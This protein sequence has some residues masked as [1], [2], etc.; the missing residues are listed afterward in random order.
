[1]MDINL[2]REEPQKVKDNMIRKGYSDVSIVDSVSSMDESWRSMKKEVDNLRYERNKVSKEINT[3]KK[4]GKD[5]SEALNRAK[6]IPSEIKAIED[7][8]DELFSQIKA[9][10]KEIPNILHESVPQGNSDAD[11]IELKRFG[12]EPI[13]KEVKPHQVLAEELGVADFDSAA[14]TSGA[15]FY[16]LEGELALLNQALIRLAIET[17]YKKGFQYVETPLLIRKDIIDYVA[18]LADQESMIYKIEGEDLFLIGTSEHS[19]IGRFV[20]QLIPAQ[21]LPIK[22]TSYSM[23]FRREKG[24]HG[25]DEK[26]LFRTHQ[27]NKVEM[28]VICQP[29]ESMKFFDEMWNITVEIFTSLGLPTRTLQICT[30]DL[31]VLKH[32][33]YDVEVYSPR[34]DEWIEV[35]SCSNLTTHQARGLG[36]RADKGGEKF[37]PHTLNNTAI[38]TS[39]ALVSILETFQQEDGSVLIPE[40]LHK[41]MMGITKIEPKK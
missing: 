18:D 35:G 2:I 41:Y 28:V 40:V 11:N 27:F 33:Q 4:E 36:I 5:A 8:A 24:S 26:G 22:Q 6:N 7:K 23:C 21:K 38:A 13:K 39:R 14:K 37:T 32:I 3:L 29:E 34:R 9:K 15:G 20:G 17:M 25:L 10:L 1:M 12:P 31:N 16:Y 19:L 30:G